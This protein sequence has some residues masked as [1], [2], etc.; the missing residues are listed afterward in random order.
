MRSLALLVIRFYQ[1]TFSPDH[2]W[3]RALY[4]AGYC[5]FQPSC[6][7]YTFKAIER[8]GLLRGAWLGCGRILRCNP[9][10]QGGADPL[11][12]LK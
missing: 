6:S 5:K 10:H 7:S 12:S 1:H 8:F 4:P 2:G 11:P 9:W 3:L